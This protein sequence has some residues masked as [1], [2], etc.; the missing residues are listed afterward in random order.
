MSETPA[1]NPLDAP[2]VAVQ[3]GRE[4]LYVMSDLGLVSAEE[5]SQALAEILPSKRRLF[6]RPKL[7]QRF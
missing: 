4:L 6:L 2:Q 5:T 3:R 7:R 1:L